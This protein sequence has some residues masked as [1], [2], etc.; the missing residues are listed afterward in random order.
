MRRTLDEVFLKSIRTPKKVVRYF[1]VLCRGLSL[2]IRPSGLKSWHFDFTSPRTGKRATKKLGTYP[3][4]PLSKARGRALTYRSAVEASIDPRYEPIPG[5]ATIADLMDV[6]LRLVVKPSIDP[7]MGTILRPGLRTA[8][9]IEWRYAKYILPAVG[10]TPLTEFRI[11]HLNKVLDPVIERGRLRLA[12]MLHAD[13][14]TI[15]NFAVMRGEMPFNPLAKVKLRGIRGDERERYLSLEEVNFVWNEFP[16]AFPR[17]HSIPRIL[18]L[19]LLTGQRVGEVCGIELGEL[20]A[21]TV[22][23]TIP[24]G[25]SKNG[26]EH[27]VPLSRLAQK[28]ILEALEATNSRYLFP[29][30]NGGPYHVTTVCRALSRALKPTSTLPL[31][32]LKTTHWTTHDLRRTV[33]TQMSDAGNGLNISELQ[34]AH[35]LN[36]RTLTRQSVTQR[37]YNKNRYL[38]EKREALEKWAS[39]LAELVSSG[40]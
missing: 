27:E 13:I 39:L 11:S 31:G 7:K 4:T 28:I 17:S 36:H 18:R 1:D 35:I 29:N 23:W 20:D 12:G 6:R 38:R 30:K 16:R 2:I 40:N 37:V 19:C 9:E 32:R 22:L 24:K 10:D 25:R 21:Q 34:I 14:Q 8:R 15:F 33:A 5:G 26:Y 3:A